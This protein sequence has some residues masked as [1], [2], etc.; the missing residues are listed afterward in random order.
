MYTLEEI[1]ARME[2]YDALMRYSKGIDRRDAELLE[3]AY[4]PD[5]VDIRSYGPPDASPAGFAQRALEGFGELE[6]FSQHHHTNIMMK[7]DVEAGVA[8]VESYNIAVHPIGPLS[9]ASQRPEDGKEHLRMIGG[10]YLDRFE[11]RD[12]EWRIAKRVCVIDWSRSDVPGEDG[13]TDIRADLQ[14]AGV[15]ADPSYHV[16]SST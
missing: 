1:S 4:F 13:F 9:G 8:E 15:G 16:M 10:R 7:V 14:S 2:I 3:S 11:R 5:A 12:G 6:S